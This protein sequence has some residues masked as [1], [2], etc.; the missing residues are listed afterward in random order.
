[1]KIYALLIVMCCST[2]F[3]TGCERRTPDEPQRNVGSLLHMGGD[4]CT[5]AMQ[6]AGRC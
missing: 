3:V 2:L 5:E 1:M 6:N 4:V